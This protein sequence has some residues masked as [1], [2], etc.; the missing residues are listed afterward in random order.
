MSRFDWRDVLPPQLAAQQITWERMWLIYRT[1]TADPKVSFGRMARKFGVSS[2]HV[3]NQFEKASRIVEKKSEWERP[4]VVRYFNYDDHD[5]ERLSKMKAARAIVKNNARLATA[6]ARGN[7]EII[8]H[9][10]KKSL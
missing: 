4:P 3:R 2:S 5:L 1:R 10:R 9:M 6:I 8:E 7:S